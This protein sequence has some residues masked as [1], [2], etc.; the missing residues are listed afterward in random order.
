[1]YLDL[2]SDPYWQ[3]SALDSVLVWYVLLLGASAVSPLI[4]R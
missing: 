1:V 4:K 3:G 2:T